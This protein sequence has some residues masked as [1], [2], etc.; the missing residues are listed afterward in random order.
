MLELVKHHEVRRFA[1]GEVIIIEQGRS[2]GVM[3]VLIEGE[4]EVLR[5]GTL[6]ARA[7]QAGVIFGEM[8]V[9]LKAPP[10]ATVR[11]L[12][13]STLAVVPNPREF[14]EG[15]PEASLYLAELLA[16]RLDALTKYLVDVKQQFEGHD[17]LGMVDRVLETLMHR[18]RKGP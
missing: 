1:A 3:F 16:T 9:L 13:A 4:V 12:S 8:A 6:V 15:S 11:A 7:A 18:P 10:S 5:D 14:L 2:S 17:H